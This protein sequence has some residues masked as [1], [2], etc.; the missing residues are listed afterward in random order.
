MGSKTNELAT[1]DTVSASGL[2]S[3]MLEGEGLRLP[4]PLRRVFL[5]L[6]TEEHF[7]FIANVEPEIGHPDTLLATGD[8]LF[9]AD[10]T[11]AAGLDAL[12][13][14]VIHRIRALPPEVPALP[15][16]ALGLVALLFPALSAAG[17]GRLYAASPRAVTSSPECPSLFSPSHGR[18]R[19]RRPRVRERAW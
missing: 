6:G 14:G 11:S 16:G 8:A 12:G 17:R 5:D 3:A 4:L 10:L 9:V 19:G 13:T 15:P 18:T 7:H 1:V 2:V